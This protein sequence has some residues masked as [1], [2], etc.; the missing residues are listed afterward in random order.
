MKE[1]TQQNKLN[2]S[3]DLELGNEKVIT[4]KDICIY[5][6]VT[7]FTSY[8]YVALPGIEDIGVDCIDNAIYIIDLFRVKEELNRKLAKI[9]NYYKINDEKEFLK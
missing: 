3:M 7:D 6:K 2:L 5:Y 8:F 9:Y 1:L 4:Y